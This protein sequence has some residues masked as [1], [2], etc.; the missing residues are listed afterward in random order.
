MSFGL[1]NQKGGVDKT[2]LA[3][4]LAGA[5]AS[6]GK[7]IVVVDTDP[8]G[9]E[10][11]WSDQR[12]REAS[13]WL[14]GVLD[15][16]RDT[17]APWGARDRARRRSRPD[18][19]TSAGGNRDALGIARCRSHRDPRAAISVRRLGLG[20][21]TPAA[22]GGA[23]I[24]PAAHCPVRAQSLQ[25]PHRHCPRG[26]GSAGHH[27][28]SIAAR[29]GQRAFADA[30][31]T[32]RQVCQMPQGELAMREVAVLAEDRTDR[33]LKPGDFQTGLRRA[34]KRS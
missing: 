8:K 15:L 30:T 22:P 32:S 13:P 6:N 17:L 23:A 28:P 7:R 31:R 2:T 24:P 25:P 11:D 1:L 27:E 26:G 10:L 19:R 9:F 18:R 33:A 4:H 12:A 29:V 5:W 20:R 3:L 14:F 21:D 34:A 16:A